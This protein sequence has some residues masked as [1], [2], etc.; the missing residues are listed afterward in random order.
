MNTI[1]KNK[2]NY[3]CFRMYPVVIG[4]GRC[5]TKDSVISGYQIPK[6][7]SICTHLLFLT[8]HGLIMYFLMRKIAYTFFNIQ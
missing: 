5:M 6:G 8:K 1:P 4:N 2:L 7:V 3:F